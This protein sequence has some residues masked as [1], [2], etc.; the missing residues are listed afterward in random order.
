M[1]PEDPDSASSEADAE[2][3][4]EELEAELDDERIEAKLES[5]QIEA[6]L[7]DEQLE[8]ELDAALGPANEEV[9]AAT[10][11]KDGA[12]TTDALLANKFLDTVS[13]QK[14]VP[15]AAPSE[16]S[17]L[18]EDLLE[19]LDRATK[20]AT[21]T[22]RIFAP[23]PEKTSRRTS[24]D[25]EFKPSPLAGTSEAGKTPEVVR[26]K[27]RT[28]EDLDEALDG[29]DEVLRTD[30]MHALRTSSE[31]AKLQRQAIRER[32]KEIYRKPDAAAAGDGGSAGANAAAAA[33]DDDDD[34]D[35][36]DDSDSDSEG[37]DKVKQHEIN[38]P[39]HAKR[40][41]DDVFSGG[42]C[43]IFVAVLAALIGFL[44][45]YSSGPL[46][47]LDTKVVRFKGD[48]VLRTVVWAGQAGGS[49]PG[50]TGPNGRDTDWAVFF[51]KPYCG[52]CQRVWPAFRALGATT[53]TSGRLRF[54]EV[55]CVSDRHVCN[56][57]KA[58]KHPVIR[59][60]RAAP[61][62]PPPTTKAGEEAY[63]KAKATASRGRGME[64]RFKR[65]VATEWSGLLIAYEVVNWFMSLQVRSQKPALWQGFGPR[66]RL[67]R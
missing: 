50:V 21:A 13:A 43:A 61:P 41:D 52:A 59:I 1:A 49:Q 45:W 66:L 37:D 12:L 58:D 26:Q 65:E 55:D 25:F 22:A 15:S 60:Y 9:D 38:A 42:C 31:A 47:P 11:T 62:P 63:E 30:G 18:L 46:D 7:D 20:E 2:L 53:N 4:E 5:E 14:Q 8:A 56:M 34:S 24:K 51:Y 33:D 64:M 10:P 67:A 3:D 36:S 27:R 19:D 40:R 39:G 57:L 16:S 29:L 6:E 32:A 44:F 35:D 23:T 28:Y 54:G 17:E 48:G